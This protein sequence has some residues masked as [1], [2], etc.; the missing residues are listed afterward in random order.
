[1]VDMAVSHCGTFIV[2][3]VPDTRGAEAFPGDVSLSAGGCAAC[4][5]FCG[6][7]YGL[8]CFNLSIPQSEAIPSSITMRD[9]GDLYCCERYGG[10][11]VSQRN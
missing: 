1:M 2:N 3:L 6:L 10:M 7:D 8:D 9:C 5:W 4:E 11:V